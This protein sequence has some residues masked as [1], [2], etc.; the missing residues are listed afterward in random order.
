VIGLD[1]PEH[2]TEMTQNDPSRL[3][4]ALFEDQGLD[5]VKL[6]FMPPSIV[7]GKPYAI[8]EGYL[9]DFMQVCD[10][11]DVYASYEWS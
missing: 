3:N 11:N 9:S 5:Y 10:L 8:D 7:K 2:L 4:Y 6:E 1:E